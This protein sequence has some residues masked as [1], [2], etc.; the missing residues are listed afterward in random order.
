M[1]SIFTEKKIAILSPQS[2]NHLFI[3]KHHY[4]T[5]LAKQNCVLFVN[6][7]TLGL[8]PNHH[9]KRLNDRLALLDFVVPLPRWIK[10]KVPKLYK[11]CVGYTL[12]KVLKKHWANIDFCFDFGVQNHIEDL[13]CVPGAYKVFFPV[14]DDRALRPQA[15]G[16]NLML[17][18]SKNIQEK[19]S[20]FSNCF[21]IN[22][23]LSE[24]F[25]SITQHELEASLPWI[26]TGK[27]KVGYAGNL[28]I[29]FLDRQVLKA[30]ILENP[31]IEF[32][33]FGNDPERLRVDNPELADLL[34]SFSNV[35][36]NGILTPKELA[37]SYRKLDAFLLC[38]K[39]DYIK[40]HAE[41]SHKV[42]E[43]LSTGRVV[44]S[45]Y[46]SVYDGCELIE[47][48]TKDRN[49]DLVMIAKD[50]FSNIVQKN[51]MANSKSRMRFALEN[52]YAK[53]LERIGY[54]IESNLS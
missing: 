40:Y 10:F 13:R 41:N 15:R 33:F 50:V 1:S 37:A 32:H 20:R 43:Y 49:E 4:A 9:F 3:S 11:F 48:S 44:I 26:H 5:E 16:F 34:C 22:H 8:W 29:P 38:Y 31:D 18:V 6:P 36:L 2:W 19:F 30:I 28:A 25:S 7:P 52:S 23:G 42:L 27:L 53:N 12:S 17:T 47:M 21:F 24:D 35:V 46:L 45:T 14:D 51:S 54:F 39:P